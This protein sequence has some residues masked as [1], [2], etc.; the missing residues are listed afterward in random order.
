MNNFFTYNRIKKQLAARVHVPIIVS[1]AKKRAGLNSR[2]SCE[3]PPDAG[4]WAICFSFVRY[5][6]NPPASHIFLSRTQIH[7]RSGDADRPT[8]RAYYVG[9]KLKSEIRGRGFCKPAT[10]KT[11]RIPIAEKYQTGQR[12]RGE[13]TPS[14]GNSANLGIAAAIPGAKSALLRGRRREQIK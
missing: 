4:I 8:D 10:A 11:R 1:I 14:K 6:R 3:T 9:M 2:R 5:A 12:N 7:D 13:E